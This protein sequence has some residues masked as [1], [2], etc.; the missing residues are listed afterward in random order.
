MPAV[1]RGNVGGD[2]YLLSVSS[3]ARYRVARFATGRENVLATAANI[4]QVNW[5]GKSPKQSAQPCQ[6]PTM[7]LSLFWMNPRMNV[8]MGVETPAP[9]PTYSARLRSFSPTGD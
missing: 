2:N 9:A 5:P 4:A 3:L 6:R 8:P 7:S 1:K